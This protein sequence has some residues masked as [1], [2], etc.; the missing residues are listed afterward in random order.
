MPRR[1]LGVALLIPRNLAPEIDGIRRALGTATVGQVPP[2]VTLVPPTNVHEEDIDDAV[3]LA[4]AAAADV[5]PLDVV[6]GPLETFYPVTPVLYLRVSGPGLAGIVALRDALDAGPFAQELTHPFVPHVTLHDDAGDDVI[7]GAQ[8]SIDH[9]IEPVRF[10]AVTIL[11]Q[12]DDD[13]VWRP[14]A[15]APLGESPTTRTIGASP[16][17]FAVTR[18]PTH[19]GATMGRYRSLSVEALVD[20]RVLGLAH[21]HYARDGVAWLDELVVIAETRGTG[22]GAQLARAFVDAARDHQA[23]EVRAARGATIAGFLVRLGF[24]VDPADEFSLVL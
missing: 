4:R 24:T 18:Y 22:I 7:R 23:T 21:G 13:K 12:D 20:G 14:I 15:D 8:A 10:D 1:R 19:A 9:F 5:A 3:A 16:V 17:S 2:H 11:E 6:V